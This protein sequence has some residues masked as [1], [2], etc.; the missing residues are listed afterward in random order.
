MQLHDIDQ[1]LDVSFSPLN[2]DDRSINGLPVELLSHIFLIGAQ[3]ED[4]ISFQSKTQDSEAE[5]DNSLEWRMLITRIC[6]RW[7][8]VAIQ[9]AELWTTL[10]FCDEPPGHKQRTYLERSQGAPLDIDVANAVAFVSSESR[11]QAS[12]AVM[13]TFALIAPHFH[14]WRSLEITVSDYSLM[15]YALRVLCQCPDARMLERLKLYHTDE[16]D[17]DDTA[18]Q[19]LKL[20]AITTAEHCMFTGNLPSLKD[21]ALSGV[22]LNWSTCIFGPFLATLELAYHPDVL[23]P[24]YDDFRRFVSS[25]PHLT[26]LRIWDSGPAGD[27]K[28]WGTSALELPSLQTLSLKYMDPVRAEF[29]VIRMKMPRLVSLELD[30]ESEPSQPLL[31]ALYTAHPIMKHVIFSKLDTLRLC[32]LQCNREAVQ[33]SYSTLTNLRSLELNFFFISRNWATALVSKPRPCRLLESLSVSGLKASSLRTLVFRR[34]VNGL[35]LKRL[36]V[37]ADTVLPESAETWLRQHV[38]DFA[39]FEDSDEETDDETDEATDE[40]ESEG[41]ESDSDHGE[42]EEGADQDNEGQ[43]MQPNGQ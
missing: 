13:A 2:Y 25:A 33:N 14:R 35:P 40:D 39:L 11:A 18:T 6:R 19:L 3:E 23:R 24:T 30:F 43:E 37:G 27:P 41:S 1:S 12:F 17:V 26:E 16:D 29:L 28:S 7:R 15:D 4:S 21:L 31:R 32:G 20:D 9:T 8:H 22:P 38:P 5:D 10:T 36:R 42:F 34:E